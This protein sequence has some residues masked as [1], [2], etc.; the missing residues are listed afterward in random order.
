MPG[1]YIYLYV[2]V[3]MFICTNTHCVPWSNTKI[4]T[5]D[6]IHKPNYKNPIKTEFQCFLNEINCYKLFHKI[7]QARVSHGGVA[8]DSNL[9]GCYAMSTDKQLLT[10]QKS[11]TPV[12]DPEGGV[13][14]SESLTTIYQ[15]T[16]HKISEELNLHSSN[17]SQMLSKHFYCRFK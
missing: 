15:L 2:Y 7:L 13:C 16:W 8:K 5:M 14:S 10:F 4:Y 9:L 3:Y 6:S 12:L 17:D 1:Y 11:T